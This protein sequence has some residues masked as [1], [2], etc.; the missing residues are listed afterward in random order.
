[1]TKVMMWVHSMYWQTMDWTYV[2]L[3]PAMVALTL[4]IVK[5]L[6]VLTTRKSELMH[7]AI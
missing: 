6:A 2:H 1:M 7:S 4:M 5:R 3:H